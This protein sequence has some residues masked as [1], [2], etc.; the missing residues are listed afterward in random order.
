MSKRI[1]RRGFAGAT[2]AAT[3]GLTSLET[4]TAAPQPLG[5]EKQLPEKPAIL[6]VRPYQLMCILCRLGEGRGQDL[7]DERLSQILAAVQED[8]ESPIRLRLNTESVYGFQNPGHA[9]RYAR[10]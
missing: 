5:T 2:A 8:P 9:R 6:E 7:G 1:T 3:I 4:A 10:G